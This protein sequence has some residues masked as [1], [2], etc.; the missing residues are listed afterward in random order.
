[1]SSHNSSSFSQ[2]GASGKP[3]AV[4]TDGVKRGAI[5]RDKDRR[6][7]RL[8]LYPVRYADDFLIFVTGSYEEAVAERQAL[9]DWL[10]EEMGL[11]LS[12]QKRSCPR[13]W[14]RS[15]QR[16]TVVT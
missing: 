1:M 13:A 6:A 8:I 3:G 4:H 7:G 11:T 9:A 16:L 10:R 12:E 15:L 5:R 14:C 2:D